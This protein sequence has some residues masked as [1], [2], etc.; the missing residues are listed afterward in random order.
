MR[1]IKFRAWT[2]GWHGKGPSSKMIRSGNLADTSSTLSV[3]DF[4]PIKEG[5]T[6]M[7]FTGLKDKSGKEIYE[8]DI[9]FH[10]KFGEYSEITYFE[11]GMCFIGLPV[12]KEVREDYLKG[13]VHY[14]DLTCENL[15]I[16]KCRVIG[17]IY[18][19]PELLK[20]ANEDGR[21]ENE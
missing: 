17:N 4:Y 11:R 14:L 6:L 18:E 8:G 19:N 15:Q 5:D 2:H 10:E 9:I 13:N 16:S 7:Q 21:N 12:E 1:E 3:V 20:G